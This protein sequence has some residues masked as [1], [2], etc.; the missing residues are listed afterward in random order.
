MIKAVIIDASIVA[1]WLLEDEKESVQ[2]SL[3]KNDFLQNKISIQVPIFIYYEV[4]NLLK[5]AVL[6][7]RVSP[8]KAIKAYSGFLDLSFV[9][10]SSKELLTATLKQAFE[11]N[12]SS[13]D[14]SYVALAEYL[15]IPF[16]TADLKLLKK[17]KRNTLVRDL[18]S[19]N[20]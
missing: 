14:A 11:M 8:K 6:S 7:K 10:H 12:I 13:Y 9:T 18:K 1:K 4:N 3:I 19:F 5:S 15:Q 17:L 2:A 16:Y 20:Y